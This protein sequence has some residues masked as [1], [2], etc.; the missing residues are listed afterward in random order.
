M[1]QAALLHLAATLSA[2]D[3]GDGGH[4][5]W[6]RGTGVSYQ[7]LTTSAWNERSDFCSHFIG[8][9]WSHDT[10]LN[11]GRSYK[12]QRNANEHRLC[13]SFAEKQLARGAYVHARKDAHNENLFKSSLEK[14]QSFHSLDLK[15]PFETTLLFLFWS[16]DVE[17][18]ELKPLA[19]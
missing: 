10:N 4:W 16:T 15:G 9:H 6:K 1:G 13:H 7:F 3:E 8:Q 5:G 12:R 18:S 14:I 17:I 2:E 19:N 11:G